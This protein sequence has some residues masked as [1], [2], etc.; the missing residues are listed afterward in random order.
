MEEAYKYG[1]VDRAQ[2]MTPGE[3]IHL[4]RS[5]S[6]AAGSEATRKRT[7]ALGKLNGP[8]DALIT[9]VREKR[10]SFKSPN[11]SIHGS[12]P[13]YEMSTQCQKQQRATVWQRCAKRW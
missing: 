6:G 7:P 12:L 10:C 2:S 1:A 11:S 13:F 8:A 9:G 5:T 3:I 4:K